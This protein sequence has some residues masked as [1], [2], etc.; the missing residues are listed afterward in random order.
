MIS[1]PELTGEERD[2]FGRALAELHGRQTETSRRFG[3]RQGGFDVGADWYEA[4]KKLLQGEV[5]EKNPIEC[6]T[7]KSPA[8]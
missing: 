5:H 2:L 3:S 8:G 4:L 1:S 7:P 6:T